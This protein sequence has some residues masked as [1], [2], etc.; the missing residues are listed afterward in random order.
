MR[1]HILDPIGEI[2]SDG[3]QRISE[4][5]EDARIRRQRE[6]G[7]HRKARVEQYAKE[8]EAIHGRVV[9]RE[10]ASFGQ[11]TASP[12]TRTAVIA[13][14]PYMFEDLLADGGKAEVVHTAVQLGDDNTARVRKSAGIAS[15]NRRMSC[16][17]NVTVEMTA[18]GLEVTLPAHFTPVS[19]DYTAQPLNGGRV[20]T[21]PGIRVESVTP[22]EYVAAVRTFQYAGDVKVQI[23]GKGMSL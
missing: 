8:Q 11:Q 4:K 15:H 12:F 10:G 13:P 21:R 23:A 14:P 16:K 1:R 5:A 22:V 9:I 17:S 7:A 6:R 19:N 2:A 3:A 18:D 20:D